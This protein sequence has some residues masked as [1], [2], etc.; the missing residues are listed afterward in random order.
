MKAR[1]AKRGLE[2]PRKQVRYF[3]LYHGPEGLGAR[4]FGVSRHATRERLP[5]GRD[6]SVG[7]IHSQRSMDAHLRGA[8]TFAEWCHDR[9]GVKSVPEQLKHPDWG[10][11][12]LA[13]LAAHGLAPKTLGAYLTAVLKLVEVVC[14]GR[15]AKWLAL[16]DD[17]PASTPP[18]DRAWSPEEA[19]RLIAH[20]EARDAE[21]GLA[22]RV[23]DATGARVHEVLRSGQ[24]WHHALHVGQIAGAR[25]TLIG[26]GGKE[27]V[28]DLPAELAAD[29]ARWVAG[30]PPEAFVFAVPSD[31]LYRLLRRACA[32]LGIRHDGAHALRY[33]YVQ[34][35]HAALVEVGVPVAEA[36]AR[37]SERIGH[38]RPGITRRYLARG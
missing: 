15:R 31:R 26:K 12:W 27:R 36:D 4:A 21:L 2:S 9:H 1:P 17:L 11:E 22:L 25:A 35:E 30:R 32:D 38:R 29:L 20:I 10:R 3:L 19:A 28:V 13:E 34:R 24:H 23:I 16:R 6:V 7:K 18:G 37:V 8:T 14:P 5:H 33:G